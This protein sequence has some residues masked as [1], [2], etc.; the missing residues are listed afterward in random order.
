MRITIHNAVSSRN[1]LKKRRITMIQIKNL[2]AAKPENPWD[3]RVD[4]ASVLGNPFYLENESQRDEV[5]NKYEEW[6]RTN[7]DPAFQMMLDKLCKLYAEYGQLNLFCWCAPKRCHSE[8][9]RQYVI[10]RQIL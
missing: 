2:K 9:I 8:T 1:K 5:C 10:E 3:V 4:R 7:K 6:F